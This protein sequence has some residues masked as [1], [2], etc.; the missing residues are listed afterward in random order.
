MKKCMYCLTENEDGAPFCKNC[1][2]G[3]EDGAQN[4]ARGVFTKP[5]KTAGQKTSGF[6]ISSLV[7]GAVGL[8]FGCNIILGVLAIVFAAVALGKIKSS[9]EEGKA[10]AVVGLILGVLTVVFGALTT[11]LM[12]TGV[13]ARV[14]DALGGD[15]SDAPMGNLPDYIG[16][17]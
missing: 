15:L 16:K 2:A 6:A 13:F 14:L 5:V 4:G 8:F 11:A 17:M 9:G 7:L 1:G 12:F 3:F 10:L